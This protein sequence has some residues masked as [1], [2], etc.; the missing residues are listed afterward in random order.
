MSI[1]EKKEKNLNQLISKL[2]N[3]TSTYSHSSYEVEKI[4]TERNEI[5]RQKSK[6]EKK[7]E[8]L[9]RE[10]KYLKEKIIKLQEEVNKKSLI[11]DKFNQVV[12]DIKQ[13][14]EKIKK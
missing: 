8:E 10:H 7:N 13:E 1:F 12:S 2:D 9:T 14:I 3:L 11:E 5:L 4:K 6:I